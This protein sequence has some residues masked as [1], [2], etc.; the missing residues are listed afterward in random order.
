MAVLVPL[1]RVLAVRRMWWKIPLYDLL[2]YPLI[3]FALWVSQFFA[4]FRRPKYS[5]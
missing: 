2:V 1:L 3:L 4:S 5:Y